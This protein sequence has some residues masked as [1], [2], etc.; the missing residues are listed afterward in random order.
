VLPSISVN[1]NV[2][3]PVGRF[4]IRHPPRSTDKRIAMVAQVGDHDVAGR[5]D[6][7]VR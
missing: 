5:H 6:M 2:T 7:A 4:A 3:V 1:R